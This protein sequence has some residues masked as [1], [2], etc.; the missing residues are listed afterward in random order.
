MGVL[1]VVLLAAA[2]ASGQQPEPSPRRESVIVTGVYEPLPLH[3]GDRSVTVLP[4]RD[5]ELLSTSLADFLRLDASLDLRHRAPNAVQSDLSIR[6]ATFGQTLVLLNGLRLNDAQS[7]HHNM[8]VPV[9]MQAISRIEVLRGSGSTL[10]GSDAVG[11]VVNVLAEPPRTAE[12]RLRASAGSFGSN[13]QGGSLGLVTGGLS[14]QFAFSRDFSTGFRPNRD[15]R[16]L[17]LSSI[18]HANTRLGTTGLTLAHNDRPFGAEGFYGNFNS[19]ER[20]KGW[21]A[22]LHQAVGAQTD[23]SVAYRRH[24]DLFVL[25]RDRPQVFTNRHAVESFQAALRRHQVLGRNA[26]L[27]YGV[28]GYRDSIDSNNLGNHARARASGYVAFDTRALRRFSLSAGL[29][30][31]I[32]GGLSSQL[33]P[34]LSGGAWITP[35]LKLRAS[36]SRAFR[37][38]SFTELYYHDPANVGSPDLRPEQAWSYEFG[39]NWQAP[40]GVFVQATVFQR[41]DTDVIDFIRRSPNDLW[42]ATNFHKLHFLGVEFSM[43]ATVRR[44]QN[45]GVRYTTLQGSRELPT[46]MFSRYVFNYPVQA[47]VISW[48]G[49]TAV[50][51]LF[52]T[53]IGVTQRYG[54]D[55]YALWDSYF[56]FTRWRARPFLQISNALSTRYEEVAGVPMPGRAVMAGLEWRVFGAR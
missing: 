51:L 18:T 54:R 47:A 22:G 17:S 35:R 9:P 21:F 38:P 5:F 46:G 31:E 43:D 34:S 56:A 49:S 41:R 40:R 12:L 26:K 45:I 19:W 32:Y 24:T 28:E 7:G 2:A 44:S 16:N 23:V 50:G 37:I 14:Q 4:V 48:T 1:L 39:A 33:S 8:D 52:R 27:H 36:A 55:A 6:G 25:Y 15:F 20:T 53:R 30:E 10:Y 13:Q 3:E 11:G 42:R 29:R